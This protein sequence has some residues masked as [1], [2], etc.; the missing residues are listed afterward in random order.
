[1]LKKIYDLL[2]TKIDMVVVIDDETMRLKFIEVLK[3]MDVN[4]IKYEIYKVS[5]NLYLVELH[6]PYNRYLKM[7]KALIKRGYNLRPKSEAD[8]VN[9]M[10]KDKS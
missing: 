1:M 6:M 3:E 7:M 5:V 10:I 9:V 2:D 8:I 4:R